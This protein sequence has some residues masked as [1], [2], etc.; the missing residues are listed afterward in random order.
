LEKA[1]M[2]G[3]GATHAIRAFFPAARP[4][5]RNIK[6]GVNLERDGEAHELLRADSYDE[7]ERRSGCEAGVI[8]DVL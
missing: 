4:A 1:P 7:C 3:I 2:K 8:L 5:R 6:F